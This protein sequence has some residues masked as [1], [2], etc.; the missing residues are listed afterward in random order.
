MLQ[1]THGYM[2]LFQEKIC[3]DICPRV[4]LMRHMVVLHLVFWGTSILFSIVVAPIYIPTNS[5]GG[6]PFLHTFSAFFICGLINDG[7]FDRYE[8]VPH[9]SFD[10]HFYNHQWFW[11]FFMCFLAICISSLEKCLFRSYA[12]FSVGLGFFFA[13]ELNKLFV[14]FRD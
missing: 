10:L 3:P 12:H 9:S 14:Y 11:A 5:V 2:C 4:E 13:V 8:V 6:F 7:H 1:W